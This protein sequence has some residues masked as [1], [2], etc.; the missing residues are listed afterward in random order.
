VLAPRISL[1]HKRPPGILSL[2]RYENQHARL[3]RR[4]APARS[5]PLIPIGREL[6]CL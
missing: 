5:N 4:Y 2:Y 1:E 3:V 6:G